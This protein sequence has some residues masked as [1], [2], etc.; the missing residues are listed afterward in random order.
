[1]SEDAGEGEIFKFRILLRSQDTE[2]KRVS[3]ASF[4]SLGPRSMW[5][6]SPQ[7]NL[8]PSTRRDE[9]S[10]V[11][12]ILLLSPSD[13]RSV[14]ETI[15]EASTKNADSSKNTPVELRFYVVE[16]RPEVLARHFL[17]LHILYDRTVPVRQRAA[18]YLEVFGNASVRDKTAAYLEEKGKALVDLVLDGKEQQGMEDMLDLSLLKQ[19]ELDD[20]ADVFASWRTSQESDLREMRDE[21]LRSFYRDRYDCREGVVDWDYHAQVKPHASIIHPIQFR[22]WRLNG[23]AFEFGVGAAYVRDNPSLVGP[24]EKRDF[25]RARLS[26]NLKMDVVT[27]P[28]VCH[29]ATCDRSDPLADGLFEIHNKGTGAEQHRYSAT[30]V[31]LYNIT[32]CMWQVGTGKEYRMK[33]KGDVLSGLGSEEED[34]GS[35]FQNRDRN[36]AAPVDAKVFPVNDPRKIFKKKFRKFFDVAFVSHGASGLLRDS[37]LLDLLKEDA[38]VVVETCR[39]DL[40]KNASSKEVAIKIIREALLVK[41]NIVEMD[42]SVALGDCLLRLKLRRNLF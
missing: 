31:A 28:F 37:D 34:P 11:V 41:E 38:E 42:S 13:P 4:S 39:F 5:G 24:R 6:I 27:G 14:L 21:V 35:P 30:D 2:T 12:N 26:D 15:A 23:Q 33:L 8:L 19:R 9:T 17:L 32:R 18:L 36:Q 3:L 20:L 40:T 7:T 10:D 22:D 1:M 25:A 29:G 16:E